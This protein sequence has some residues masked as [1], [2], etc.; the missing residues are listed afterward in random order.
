MAGIVL[1]EP[2]KVVKI[3]GERHAIGPCVKA[4]AHK[5]C[6]ATREHAA[7]ICKYCNEPL[8]YDRMVYADAHDSCLC[9]ALEKENGG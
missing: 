2:G 5:D 6:A 4:C 9:D 3:N 8:G 7:R 1:P